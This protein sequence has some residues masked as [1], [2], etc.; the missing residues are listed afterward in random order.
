VPDQ[1][2]PAHRRYYGDVYRYVRRRTRS[3][4]DAEDVTQT[5]FTEA[6]AGLS[7]QRRIHRPHSPG[8][9]QSLGVD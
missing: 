5:V 3:R 7:N 9:T 1:A 2:E 8:S 6:V 4:E